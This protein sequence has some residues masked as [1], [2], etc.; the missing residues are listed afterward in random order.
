MPEIVKWTAIFAF[1]QTNNNLPLPFFRTVKILIALFFWLLNFHQQNHQN[2]EYFLKLKST[3][4]NKSLKWKKIVLWNPV[5]VLGINPEDGFEL[6]Y[7]S[8]LIIFSKKMMTFFL[9][10][11]IKHTWMIE[12]SFKYTPDGFYLY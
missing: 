6:I 12:F 1:V 9:C 7:L 2:F 3:N 11:F 8:I 5:R 10:P 4:F